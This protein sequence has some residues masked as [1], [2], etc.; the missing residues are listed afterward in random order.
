MAN[1]LDINLLSDREIVITRS[2]EAPCNLAWASKDARDGAAA[3]GMTDGLEAGYQ[4][5]DEIPATL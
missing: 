1:K 4:G 3:T 2:C 5:L